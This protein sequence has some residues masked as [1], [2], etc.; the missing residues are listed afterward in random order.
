MDV[1]S[2]SATALFNSCDIIG[3]YTDKKPE[4]CFIS[5]RTNASSKYGFVFN[6][7]RFLK[8]DNVTDNSYRLARP[9]SDNAYVILNNCYM[10]ELVRDSAP[11]TEP[12]DQALKSDNKLKTG[13][14]SGLYI[15]L[16]LSSLSLGL[17]A[18]LSLSTKRKNIK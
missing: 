10:T 6:E 13:D 17:L 15:W 5:P 18:V 12:S 3:R 8:E 4:G 2:G 7:C 1:I 16:I 14:E 9:W 11:S